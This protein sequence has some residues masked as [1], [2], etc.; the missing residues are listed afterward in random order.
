MLYI[1]IITITTITAITTITTITTITITNNNKMAFSNNNKMSFPNSPY[2]YDSYY[3]ELQDDWKENR[4]VMIGACWSRIKMFNNNHYDGP[5]RTYRGGPPKRT[6]LLCQVGTNNY[7][8]A[9][10]SNPSK[11]ICGRCREYISTFE[12]DYNTILNGFRWLFKRAYEEIDNYDEI[13]D[14]VDDG[15]DSEEEGK[16]EDAMRP[17]DDFDRFR[18]AVLAGQTETVFK[19]FVPGGS[20]IPVSRIKREYLHGKD[21]E[22]ALEG[23]R[24]DETLTVEEY[25]ARNNI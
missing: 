18:E 7:M 6:C 19:R 16:A 11:V 12:P 9:S 24:L 14:E 4:T 13:D 5:S 17:K 10:Y 22:K 23:D 25:E 3:D 21:L 20:F 15:Y 8:R 2:D 1:S